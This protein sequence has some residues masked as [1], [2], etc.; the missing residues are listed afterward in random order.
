MSKIIDEN[1]SKIVEKLSSLKH[2]L[3]TSH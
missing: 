1:Y 2:V 3:I